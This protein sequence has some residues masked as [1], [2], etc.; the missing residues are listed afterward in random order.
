MTD[1]DNPTVEN[2]RVE[3]LEPFT[4]DELAEMALA[5]DVDAP[6]SDDAIPISEILGPG[7][8]SPLPNWYMPAPIGARRL[9]GWRGRLVRWSALSVIASFVVI[10]AYGLCNTYG[11][12]HF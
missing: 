12:L 3:A 11:Q 1:H 2:P 5:A 10:N 7:M 4:D 6:V 9:N 8:K